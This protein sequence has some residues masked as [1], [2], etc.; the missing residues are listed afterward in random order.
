MSTTSGAT[1]AQSTDRIQKTIVLRAPRSKVWRALT[2]SAQFGEWFQARLEGPFTAG[3]KVRGPMTYPGYEHLTFEATVEQMEP[4][5]LF[6]WRW[7]PGGNSNPDP[8]E[9]TTLVVFELEEVPE[10]TRLTVTETGFDRIPIARRGKAYRENDQGWT[11]QLE[12]LR[13]YVASAA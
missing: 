1:M 12:S 3:R 8:A 10:G 13:K 7:Q 11:G 4:E 6:S 2:D 5:R 9:P